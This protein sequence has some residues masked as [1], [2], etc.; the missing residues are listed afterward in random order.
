MAGTAGDARLNKSERELRAFL[1][2]HPGSH[3]LK[4]LEDTVKNASTAARSLARKGLV[5]LTPEP[6]AMP[7][8]AV[9]ARHALNA[10]QQAAFRRDPR[11]HSG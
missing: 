1:E 3:H 9:R 10:P 4:D 8:G 7:A 11:R 5:S 2:L 6:M